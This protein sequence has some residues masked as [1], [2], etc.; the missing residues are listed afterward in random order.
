[1]VRPIL[2][3]GGLRAGRDFSLAFTPEREDPGNR[4]FS[5]RTIPKVVGGIDARVR[6]LAAALYGTVIDRV[7]P[8]SSAE[9]RRG[10]QDPGEHLPRVNIALV[11]ELK[12]LFARMG[13]DVWEVIDAAATKPFGFQAVLSRARASAAT[14]FPSIRSI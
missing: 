9:R 6:Q 13:I 5:T 11:N 4:E 8:V 3:R 2:E 14:A 10:L 1:M 12:V 7:V